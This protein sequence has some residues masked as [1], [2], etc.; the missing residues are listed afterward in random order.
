MS[1]ELRQDVKAEAKEIEQQLEALRHDLDEAHARA[2][3]QE[4]QLSELDERRA[5]AADRLQL[6]L[7][8]AEE[9]RAELERK[10]AQLEE[11]RRQAAIA[12]VEEAVR[13]RDE[14]AIHVAAAI[15]QVV[16]GL[17]ALDGRREELA[18]AQSELASTG[19]RVET[20]D[21]PPSFE[22]AI[23]RLVTVVRA[24]L[25]EALEDEL[26]EAAA[27]SSRPR[28]ID[29]LPP[30]LQEAART[31]RRQLAKQRFES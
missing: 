5:E 15:T 31:R 28:A 26:L 7:R 2:A 9:F 17:E 14:T 19:H 24:M 13:R 4:G 11:A 29:E 20:P 8:Q 10:E 1:S 30:H 3:H 23:E 22:E 27:R 18:Q 21:E 6:A 25:D 12:E 16:D